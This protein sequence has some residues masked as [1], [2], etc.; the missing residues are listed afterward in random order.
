MMHSQMFRGIKINTMITVDA[1]SVVALNWAQIRSAWAIWQDYV[2][3][4]PVSLQD[5]LIAVSQAW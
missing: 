5:L 4:G 1:N 2:Q 3:I